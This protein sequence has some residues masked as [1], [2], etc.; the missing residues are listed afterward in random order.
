MFLC[1]N[2]I[3]MFMCKCTA[4]FWPTYFATDYF[5]GAI[6]ATARTQW[7][8]LLCAEICWRFDNVEWTCFVHIKLVMQI[9]F[10]TI[11]GTYSIKIYKEVKIKYFF[12]EW[13]EDV[14]YHLF[15]Y[16]QILFFLLSVLYLINWKLLIFL[17]LL[18]TKSTAQDHLQNII[19]IK[20]SKL[21][22]SKICSWSWL[23]F[24]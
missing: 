1:F 10:H 12:W 4:V 24:Y 5:E 19:K 20:W 7:W 8:H 6:K 9:N 18:M 3:L 23:K 13:C 17:T 21:K 14:T 11:H 22:E 2:W 15:L 16:T